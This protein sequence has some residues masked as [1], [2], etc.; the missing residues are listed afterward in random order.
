MAGV[1]C[2]N[3]TPLLLIRSL[4][5]LPSTASSRLPITIR[6]PEIKGRYISGVAMSNEIIAS[7]S[8]TSSRFMPGSRCMERSRLTTLPC[9]I[10]TPFG[11][12]VEP[13]VY[14]T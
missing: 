9:S 13:E 8:S 11:L 1:A 10:S 5:R 12:P 7:A 14:I 2:I 6:A 4:S 3:V